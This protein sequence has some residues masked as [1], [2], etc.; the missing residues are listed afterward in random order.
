MIPTELFVCILASLSDMIIIKNI[1][2][3]ALIICDYDYNFCL[4]LSFLDSQNSVCHFVKS[5]VDLF[6]IFQLSIGEARDHEILMIIPPL[7]SKREDVD[8]R[9]RD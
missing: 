3:M 5:P 1:D 2:V 6:T 8:P 9:Q 7:R 4:V